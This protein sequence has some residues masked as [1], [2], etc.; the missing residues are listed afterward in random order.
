M[1]ELQ[2]IN[3]SIDNKKIIKDL[4]LH[5]KEGE[6]VA[7]MGESGKGKTT[8]LNVMNILLKPISGNLIIN[9]V[10]NPTFNSKQGRKLLQNDISV[11][12]QNF[13]L[14]DN[15]TIKDNINLIY[16]NISDEKIKELLLKIGMEEKIENNISELSGGQQQRVA[17]IRALLKN[18]KIILADEP[19][20]SVD[21]KNRDKILNFLK[22]LHNEGKTIVIVTH[23]KYVAEYCDRIINLN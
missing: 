2:N 19:T 1:I 14:L 4:T 10:K 18:P 11:I 20:G 21:N 23:D 5:I 15:E 8:L 7:I 9:G 13:L 17:I 12:F 22:E 3:V 16:D 6:M